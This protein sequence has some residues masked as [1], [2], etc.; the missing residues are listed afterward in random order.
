MEV[1]IGLLIIILWIVL[2]QII[3]KR[4][5]SKPIAQRIIVIVALIIAFPMILF[6][7]YTLLN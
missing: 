4:M 3:P 2:I 1:L 7:L 6:L 5:K